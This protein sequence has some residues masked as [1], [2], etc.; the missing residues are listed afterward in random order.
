MARSRPATQQ[1][2]SG[3]DLDQAAQLI[4]ILAEDRSGDL[5]LAWEALAKRKSFLRAARAGIEAMKTRHPEA[6]TALQSEL[7]Q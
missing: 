2:K 1:T 4:E 3:K 7:A 5:A 6:H